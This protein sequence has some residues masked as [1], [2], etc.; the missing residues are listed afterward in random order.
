VNLI[1]FFQDVAGA[2][3]SVNAEYATGRPGEGN[4][5]ALFELTPGLILY[6]ETKL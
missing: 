3:G 6:Q 5:C 1:D 4:S 2:G